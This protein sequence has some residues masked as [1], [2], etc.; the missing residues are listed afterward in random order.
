MRITKE[1]LKRVIKEELDRL[2][3]GGRD[4]GRVF[5]GQDTTSRGTIG[6]RRGGPRATDPYCEVFRKFFRAVS[7]G[8]IDIANTLSNEEAY[9]NL[10]SLANDI[11]SRNISDS[12][13]SANNNI[14]KFENRK[15]IVPKAKKL[16][17]NL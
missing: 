12:R 1:Y 5:L 3:E 4:E 2:E 11:D 9:K 15:I 16:N 6:F 14:P 8:N 13:F 7:M 10:I 17:N